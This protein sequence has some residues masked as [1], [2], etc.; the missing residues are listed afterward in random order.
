M[1]VPILPKFDFSQFALKVTTTITPF[2]KEDPRFQVIGEDGLTHPMG[3]LLADLAQ[4]AE[5][6]MLEWTEPIKQTTERINLKPLLEQF[7][8]Q[9][10]YINFRYDFKPDEDFFQKNPSA[11]EAWEAL[12]REMK[13]IFE[14]NRKATE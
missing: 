9:N 7:D 5:D 13:Q 8:P 4:E 10:T 2:S 11:R 14:N 3:L 1:P 12:G 6:G